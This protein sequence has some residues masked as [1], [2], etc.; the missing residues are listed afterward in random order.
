MESLYWD[1][2]AGV[3]LLIVIISTAI[4]GFKKSIVSFLVKFIAIIVSF[5][6]SVILV[7][8]IYDSMAKNTVKEGLEKAI[9]KF[10]I[11]DEIKTYYTEKTIGLD[12]SD[13][14]LND[15]LTAGNNMDKK[16]YSLIKSSLGDT[17]KQEDAFEA[18]QNM[19]VI[20]LQEKISEEIP[21]CG[22]KYFEVLY[23]LER[24][25]TFN[26]IN[27]VNTDKNKAVEHITEVYVQDDMTE[28][29]RLILFLVATFV[30]VFIV[31]IFVMILNKGDKPKAENAGDAVAGILLGIIKGAIIIII[32]SLFVKM[33]IYTG[34]EGKNFFNNDV[35][36]ESRILKYFYNA[37]TFIMD[38]VNK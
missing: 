21:D 19:I 2:A 37:D 38:I 28:Y 25:E 6:F 36:N 4:K 13:R 9:E 18:L 1:I 29:V 11:S 27:L 17:Y 33:I 7:D 15:I 3:I 12:L 26:I 8:G 16:L 31:Q 30:L 24:E 5:I 32:I 22:G 35:I 10:S 23:D 14:Q 34:I 20:D